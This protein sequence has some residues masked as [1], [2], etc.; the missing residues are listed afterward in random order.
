MP[1]SEE[2]KIKV[3][4]MLF[5][6]FC[7]RSVKECELLIRGRDDV[8]ICEACIPVCAEMLLDFR[9]RNRESPEAI[10]AVDPSAPDPGT[11]TTREKESLS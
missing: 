10:H 4:Y 6:D 7:G 5:C 8:H 2:R 11:P 3:L 9:Q 1:P